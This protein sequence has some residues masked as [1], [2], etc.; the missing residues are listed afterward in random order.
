MAAGPVAHFLLTMLPMLSLILMPRFCKHSKHSK[1]AVLAPS[2]DLLGAYQPYLDGQRRCIEDTSYP[3]HV[4]TWQMVFFVMLASGAAL[5]NVN[6]SQG[7]LPQASAELQAQHAGRR[8][9]SQDKCTS[10]LLQSRCS[11]FCIGNRLVLGK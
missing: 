4:S 7:Q 5:W 10:M 8:I 6:H 2:A 3:D 9:C 11:Q 1:W